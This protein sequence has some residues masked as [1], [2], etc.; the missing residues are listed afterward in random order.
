MA[1]GTEDILYD[2]DSK[3]DNKCSSPKVMD[4]YQDMLM[5]KA[6]ITS[7]FQE[8][9][10]DIFLDYLSDQIQVYVCTL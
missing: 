3:V 6:E 2:S 8:R 7:F 4:S 9:G 1:Q 5:E 10:V